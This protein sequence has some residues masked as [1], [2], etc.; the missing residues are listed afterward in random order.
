M[1]IFGE[2][3]RTFGLV[4]KKEFRG[5]IVNRN[6][7]PDFNFIHAKTNTLLRYSPKTWCQTG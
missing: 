7:N 5:W 2:Q 1:P 6:Y 4:T 3:N